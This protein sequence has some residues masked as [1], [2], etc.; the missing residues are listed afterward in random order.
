[1]SIS[2]TIKPATYVCSNCGVSANTWSGRCAQC[3]E[4]NTLELRLNDPQ[5]S[6]SISRLQTE[7]LSASKQT[8]DKRI[9]SG[10]KSVDLVFGGGIVEGSVSLISGEPGMGKSTLLLQLA[11][12]VA[13]TNSVLYV[14]GE[15]SMHQ[16]STRAKRL[17]VNEE[18]LNVA[19]SNS[20]DAIAA[21]IQTAKNKLVIVDSIQTLRCEQIGATAGSTT[22]VTN[23]CALLTAA[24]KQSN[25]ALIIVG[26]VT[27]DG[28][29]AGPKLLEHTVDAVLSLEGDPSAG[30]KLLRVSKNRYGSTNETAIFEMHS[31]GLIP[32]A[33]PSA[34]L[35]AER[36]VSDGS[37]VLAAMEG[38][39]PILV[40]VQALVNPTSYGYPKR[41]ASGLDLGRL[42]LLIA[43]L[44][45]RTKLSL[46]DKDVYLNIVGGIKISEPAADLAVVMA[47]A[48]AA[49]AKQLKDNAVVFGEVGLSGEVRHVP[50]ID[51]RIAEAKQLGFEYAIGPKPLNAKSNPFLQSVR[52]VRSALNSYLS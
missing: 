30:L 51:K 49:K 23:S 40:E 24:A 20:T 41:A 6:T 52:D 10:L 45:R 17:D 4:W 19:S 33:N 29:I 9:L 38:S 3:G 14:S 28:S 12:A 50:A 25:T 36:Q 35:L 44:E 39:R 11:G 21:E 26:H 5:A 2:K 47:I 15:E 48:S 22:Q 34:L 46:G 42:N 31:R 32:V 1:M 7:T 27:K 18:K 13:K 8:G 37:V 16:L 43:M